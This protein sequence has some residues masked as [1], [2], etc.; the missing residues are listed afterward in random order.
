[1]HLY[2]KSGWKRQEDQCQKGFIP[3]NDA[4]DRFRF[5]YGENDELYKVDGDKLWVVNFLVELD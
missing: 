1:M 3:M 2:L 4:T 5:D